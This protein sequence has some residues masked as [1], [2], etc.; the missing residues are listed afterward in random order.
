MG[1]FAKFKEWRKYKFTIMIIPDS[2]KKVIQFDLSKFMIYSVMTLTLVASSYYVVKNLY[3]E[4]LNDYLYASTDLLKDEIDFRDD[5]IEKLYALNSE[6]EDEMEYLRQSVSKSALYFE[7]KLEDLNELEDHVGDLLAII[8]DRGDTALSLPISRSIDHS[9][10]LAINEEQISSPSVIDDLKNVTLSE[11]EISNIIQDQVAKYDDLIGE[12][13]SQL[14]F[15]ESYP[16]FSPTNGY[17]T[18]GYGYR[19]D[20]FSGLRS[21]HR[22]LD[23]A[24]A[25][26]TEIYAAGSGVVTY[27]GYNGNY[28]NMIVISHG[29]DY[30]TVYAHN[31]ENLVEVGDIVQKGDLIALMGT[32]GRSTGPHVHFEVHFEG[33]QINPRVT[34]TD[35]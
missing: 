20:P 24:N 35:Y 27:A 26:G 8:N 9:M 29:Y 31:N 6:Q 32:T 3:L 14:D 2:R 5:K 28:G 18:S 21:F 25:K 7:E 34:L 10:L 13:S 11:D 16:D 12:V 1:F 4:A 30:E 23:I 17:V 15:L 19:T 33:K 22:G